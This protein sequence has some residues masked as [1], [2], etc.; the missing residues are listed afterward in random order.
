M[1]TNET[2]HDTTTPVVEADI[3][4]KLQKDDSLDSTTH[5]IGRMAVGTLAAY[6]AE[7]AAS[8]AYNATVLAIRAKRSK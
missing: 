8:K 1:T 2:R 6:F 5:Q 4:V 3:S 7:K